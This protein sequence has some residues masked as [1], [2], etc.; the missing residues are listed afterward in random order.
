[1]K[2]TDAL[3]V[4]DPGALLPLAPLGGHV[5]S[6]NGIAVGT[7]SDLGAVLQNTA[8]GQL[9]TFQIQPAAAVPTDQDEYTRLFDDLSKGTG[10]LD[11]KGVFKMFKKLGRK[12]DKKE[13]VQAMKAM[14][15]GDASG[16]VTAEQLR[17]WLD[18]VD[19]TAAVPP[20]PPPA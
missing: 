7:L 11:K 3:I 16:Q 13:V 2:L 12:S 5:V 15:G 18:A 17:D 8:V 20:S 19:D 14:C 4:S 9:C 6:L 10:V 1:M